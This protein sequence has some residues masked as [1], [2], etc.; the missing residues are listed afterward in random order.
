MKTTKVIIYCDGWG[1]SSHK[2]TK[3]LWGAHTPLGDLI[4]C[5]K[6]H[7]R[8][9]ASGNLYPTDRIAEEALKQ[10]QSDVV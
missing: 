3:S 10:N 2:T 9:N 6:C 4:L 8:C 1:V 7:E 5:P